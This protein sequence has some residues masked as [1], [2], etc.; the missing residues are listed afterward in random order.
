MTGPSCTFNPRVLSYLP[1]EGRGLTG[2]LRMRVIVVRSLTVCV[3]VFFLEL[4]R[5]VVAEELALNSIGP[6][7]GIAPNTIEF[8]PLV[9][10]AVL[11]RDPNLVRAAL[12]EK[13]ADINEKVQATK[14]SR[15]GFTPIILAAALADV[16]VAKLLIENGA[17]VS[18]LDDFDRSAFWYAA[19]IHNIDVTKI[20]IRGKGASDVINFAD[21]DLKQTPLHIAVRDDDPD[22][23]RLLKSMGASP[24]KKDI[25]GETA[26]EYC[27][28]DKNEACALLQ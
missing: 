22:L 16:D 4:S 13:R 1:L 2:V 3:L 24:D 27:S 19:E 9:A 18:I 15:A 20:L 6:I 5:A 25:L 28:H 17:Q 21:K 26:L 23:V 14:G 11:T 8:I 7:V 10:R 12:V